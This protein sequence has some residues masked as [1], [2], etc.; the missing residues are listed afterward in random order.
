[1]SVFIAYFH[2]LHKNNLI[3]FFPSY[4]A[5][6][7][8]YALS[9]VV[10]ANASGLKNIVLLQKT[11]T[12][13]CEPVWNLLASVTLAFEHTHTHRCVDLHYIKLP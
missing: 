4:K 12:V 8:H 2:I 10:T 13:Y 7:L 3:H 11:S 5:F 6:G 1:M 9:I